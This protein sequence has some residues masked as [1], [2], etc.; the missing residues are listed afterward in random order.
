MKEDIPNR[1]PQIDGEGER[2]ER[3][4]PVI[5][6]A[7]LTLLTPQSLLTSADPDRSFVKLLSIIHHAFKTSSFPNTN[8]AIT[9]LS[10]LACAQLRASSCGAVILG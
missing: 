9:V 5:H 7:G 1:S 3:G 6:E 4:Q 8:Q 2:G 10:A